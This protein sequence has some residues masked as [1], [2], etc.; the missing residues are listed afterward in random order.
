MTHSFDTSAETNSQTGDPITLVY[1]CGVGTTVLVV[2]LAIHSRTARG[3][4]TPQYGAPTF[5][6]LNLTQAG[7]TQASTIQQVS[8]EIWYL[9]NPYTGS[10]LN[11]NVPNSGALTITVMASSYKASAG[12][13]SDFDVANGSFSNSAANPSTSITPSIAGDAV[14]DILADTQAGAVTGNNQTLLFKTAETNLW[15]SAGQYA[16]LTVSGSFNMSYTQTLGS[17]AQCIVAIKEKALPPVTKRR[18][19]STH[20][21]K[22]SF[23]MS[24]MKLSIRMG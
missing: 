15:D 20:N 14:V 24:T 7:S 2:G 10:A 19:I 13:T 18:S 1:T 17:Y 8:T 5:L 22:V 6:P 23:G 3:G 11:I 9:L 21:R 16:L 4:G 12:N